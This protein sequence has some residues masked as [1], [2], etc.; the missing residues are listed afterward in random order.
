MYKIGAS[1][2][3]W[4]VCGEQALAGLGQVKRFYAH[5]TEGGRKHAHSWTGFRGAIRGSHRG[6]GDHVEYL[7][8]R[9][10]DA[11]QA[12]GG[13]PGAGRD[14]SAAGAVRDPASV[15][16]RG[17]HGQGKRSLRGHGSR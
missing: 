13:H 6:S 4:T 2:L 8:T 10:A 12:A 3:V 16:H 5:A 9:R 15:R 1:K 11:P 17:D 14:R 7:R